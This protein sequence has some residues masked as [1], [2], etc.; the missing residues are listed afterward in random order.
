M[1]E[2]VRISGVYIPP[3]ADA[4]PHMLRAL[5]DL[6]SQSTDSQGNVLSHLLVGDF[7]QHSWNKKADELF[8]EWMVDTGMWE[9]SDPRVPTHRKGSTLDKF[10]LLAGTHIP[11]EW[12][13]SEMSEW[14][15]AVEDFIAEEHG[16]DASPFYPAHTY[17]FPVIADH[18]PVMLSFHGG[19]EVPQTPVKAS[20]VSQL[21][22]E[23]WAKKNAA[24]AEYLESKQTNI[25]NCIRNEQPTSL[26][27]ILQGGNQSCFKDQ[28][29]AANPISR[30]DDPFLRFCKKHI[31]D[32]D[33]PILIRAHNEDN[34]LLKR[35]LINEI[36]RRGWKAYLSKIRPSNASALFT[37]LAQQEGRKPRP[38]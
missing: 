26:L 12:L 16:P 32:P 28:F 35:K 5:T 31:D 1:G 15:G 34:D 14:G 11:E 7:N 18:H 9:L 10:L 2:V 33:N 21:S 24:M 29:R 17:N 27:K 36:S 25:Q 6:E 8:H 38:Q 19:C 3:S 4:T 22:S 13:P 20:R 23:E 30:K 37:F